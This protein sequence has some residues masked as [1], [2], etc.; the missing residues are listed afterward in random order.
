MSRR[1]RGQL[2][3]KAFCRLGVGILLV[4][5]LTV[6]RAQPQPQP[7]RL[8]PPVVDSSEL[9]TLPSREVEFIIGPQLK[10]GSKLSPHPWFD[11][12]QL[13]RGTI[14]GREFPKFPPLQLDGTVQVKKGDVI[15]RG[16]GT[17]F[18]SQVDPS[19]PAPF[20]N[21]RLRIR[22]GVSDT[23][24][25]VQVRSVQSDTQLTLTAPYAYADQTGVNADTEYTDGSNINGDVYMNANYYDLALSLYALYYRTGDPQHLAAA[26]KVA[27]SWWLS[28][29]IRSGTSRDFEK[30][31]YSPRNSSL[32]GL[33][34]RALDGRPEMWDWLRV[35]TRYLF[36]IWVKL[37]IKDPQPYQGVRDGSFMLLYAT[38]LGK[39]LPDSFPLQAGGTATNGAALRAGFLAD[40][41]N[42]AVNY[43]GRLQYPDGSWRWDDG[44]A[45]DA[46]GGTSQGIMVPFMVGLL[47]QALVDVHRATVRPDVKESIKTQLMKV[48]RHLYQ[49]GPYRKDDRVPSLSGLRWR[50]FHYVYHGGTTVNPTKWKKGSDVGSNPTAAWEVTSARQGIATNLPAY[51]YVYQITGDETFKTM[52]DELFESAFGDVTDGIHD[53]AAGTAKN[54]NQ[55]FR[56]GGRYLVWRVGAGDLRS[57]PSIATNKAAPVPAA[58]DKA[59][60]VPERNAADLFSNIMSTANSLPSLDSLDET[61]VNEFIQQIEQARQAFVAEQATYVSPTSVLRELQAALD[62]TKVA[63]MMLRSDPLSTDA[64]I[65]LGWAAARLKRANDR[66][67]KK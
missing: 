65:R 32:G 22:E 66:V 8:A 20:F 34:L 19:G 56:M 49:D 37:R 26:R 17:R 57:P 50:S 55:N 51:G 52:G 60:P 21:G 15:V 63:A 1:A 25:P 61:Q 44:Y 46:D 5:C 58:T 24:R 43:Y 13:S 42:A 11:S 53:E 12:T 29:P 28:S 33:M 35:Y 4:S 3:L 6:C 48:C 45:V 62:H 40:A 27:D 30:L 14:H 7:A 18:L 23:Y 9:V 47:T 10:M 31:G 59:V 41:E 36:D 39:V 67:K 54:Y 2:E 16:V 64:K 38:W